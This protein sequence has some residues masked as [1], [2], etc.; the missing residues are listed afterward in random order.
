MQPTLFS[1]R[2]TIISMDPFTIRRLKKFLESFRNT[3]G[4]LPT[5]PDFES[6]GFAPELVES[7]TKDGVIEK[8]FIKLTNGTV[9]KGYK[10][11]PDS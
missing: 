5:L 3:S 2:V 4:K 8:F 9:M 10:L 11:K 7:A 1:A 6:A